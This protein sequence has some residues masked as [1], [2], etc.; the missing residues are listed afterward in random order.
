MDKNCVYVGMT[1]P[2]ILFKLNFL[3]G[4]IMEKK[5]SAYS[6]SELFYSN[7]LTLHHLQEHGLLL[8]YTFNTQGD[9]EYLNFVSD[10]DLLAN[11]A[12]YLMLNGE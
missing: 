9:S 4:S 11:D 6:P 3:D 1:M 8:Y 5:I 12:S 10:T 7:L 2:I